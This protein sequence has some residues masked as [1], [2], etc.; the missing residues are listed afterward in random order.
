MDLPQGMQRKEGRKEGGKEGKA[1]PGFHGRL[2]VSGGICRG[3]SRPECDFVVR[4]C[5]SLGV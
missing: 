1:R 4:L 3:L 5:G 2:Y